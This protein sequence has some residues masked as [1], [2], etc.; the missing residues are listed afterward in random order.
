M[1]AFERNGI[2][3]QMVSETQRIISAINMVATGFG[4]AV[5]PKTM[6]SFKI[7]SVVYRDLTIQSSFTVPLNVAYRRQADAETLRRFLSACES[8]KN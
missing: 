4:I 3:L 7:R 6:E 1:S 5:V 2:R 8:I